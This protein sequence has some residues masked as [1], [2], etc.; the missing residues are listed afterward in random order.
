MHIKLAVDI[1]NMIILNFAYRRNPVV[2]QLW[3]EGRIVEGL[4]AIKWSPDDIQ[5]LE[6]TVLSGLTGVA[7]ASVS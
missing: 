4:N 2:S 3:D 7:C 5:D 1:M 6:N